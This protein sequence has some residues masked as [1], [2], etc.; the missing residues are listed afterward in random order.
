MTADFGADQRAHDDYLQ[1]EYLPYLR[2]T[3]TSEER[4]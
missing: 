2:G 3:K 4:S 1:S